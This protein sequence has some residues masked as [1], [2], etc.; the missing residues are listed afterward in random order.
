VEREDYAS[1]IENV[2]RVNTLFRIVPISI[3]FG[4]ISLTSLP[5]FNVVVTVS[6][7]TPYAAWIWYAM[8]AIFSGVISSIAPL[9]SGWKCIELLVVVYWAT[10][11]SSHARATGS[12]TTIWNCFLSM[13]WCCT[14]MVILS[15]VQMLQSGVTPLDF[16]QRGNLRLYSLWP[17]VNPIS[18]SIMATF[19]VVGLL[20]ANRLNIFLKI[21]LIAPS[22]LAMVLTKSRTGL[23][24]VLLIALFTVLSSAMGRRL[25]QATLLLIFCGCVVVATNATLKETLRVDD[26]QRVMMG[27][28]RIISADGKTSAWGDSIEF[29]GRSPIIGYGFLNQSRFMGR[30]TSTDNGLLQILLSA[31]LVGAIPVVLSLFLVISRWLAVR[32]HEADPFYNRLAAIGGSAL[33]IALAKSVTTISLSCADVSLQLFFLSAVALHALS[34]AQHFEAFQNQFDRR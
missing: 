34:N 4:L 14:A 10:A 19:S 29:F 3:C 20:H 2:Q 26:Y 6:K 8:I 21:S 32:L 30:E 13:T 5:I 24:A 7:E 18:L 9:W 11:V 28:G 16:L 31:G 1:N 23:L 27:A 22:L 12:M 25:K 33:A 15:L 17:H